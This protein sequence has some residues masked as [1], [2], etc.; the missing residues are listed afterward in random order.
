M[1][2]LIIS[3][4]DPSL[5]ERGDAIYTRNLIEGLNELKCRPD[6][7]YYGNNVVQ[8]S[9]GLYEIGESQFIN[10][11]ARAKFLVG[12]SF[13]PGMVANRKRREYMELVA[14]ICSQKS[15]DF[16]IINHFKMSFCLPMLGNQRVLYFSHNNEG[17]LWNNVTHE[18][19]T[20]RKLIYLQDWMK[21]RFYE[22][23]FLSRVN[24]V[25]V[26]SSGDK[27]ELARRTNKPIRVLR[28][29][30]NTSNVEA[31]CRSDPKKLMV[32]GSYTWRP[33]AE[34][35]IELAKCF[36]KYN[37]LQ[38]GLQLVIVGKMN[39]VTKKMITKIPGIK[40]IGFV[41][42]LTPWYRNCDISIVPETMGGGF[43]LKLSE[44]ASYGKVIYGI[45][46]AVNS[47]DFVDGLHL[48]LF[49]DIDSLVKGL[50]EDIM[51]SKRDY[52]S[53]RKAAKKLV[54]TKF[55]RE[56]FARSLKA[57]VLDEPINS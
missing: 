7:I 55:T 43:K 1:K 39:Q 44:A 50:K 45:R 10:F 47:D 18:R 35:I 32:V 31:S 34:N 54:Q 15:Y 56:E 29:I 37:L 5:A 40:C 51:F 27:G 6:I 16:V 53:L 13:L 14:K 46:D 17:L 26:I 9:N 24:M 4:E 11:S 33:K 36:E 12:L 28:P 23:R 49:D 38:L 42:D 41:E 30:I 3:W 25:S 48:L 57:L 2:V 52:S 20:W 19:S 21:T 8:D 22:D